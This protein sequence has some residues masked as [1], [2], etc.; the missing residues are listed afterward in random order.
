[1][2]DRLR[3]SLFNVLADQVA[4]KVFVDLYAG[5]GAVGLEA[6]S[7]GADKTIFV[8]SD[9]GAS[10]T[11][12]ENIASLGAEGDCLLINSQVKTALGRIT[13]DIY[14]LG[15]PYA[16]VE[17]YRR[18]LETL[19]GAPP[20]M[21]IAQHATRFKLQEQ[22]GALVRFRSIKHGSNSLSLY[23]AVEV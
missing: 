18:T 7:R 9:R 19:G 13:G 16:L 2:P 12:E 14:F 21:V 4:E 23:R 5:S 1:M 6:L 20:Y 11:I 10:R 17:E 15:P 8:E 22:Y 3:E